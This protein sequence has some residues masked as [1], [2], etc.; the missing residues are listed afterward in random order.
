MFYDICQKKYLD[1]DINIT[2]DGVPLTQVHEIKFLGVVLTD[3]LKWR[4]HADMVVNPF[5]TKTLLRKFVMICDNYWGL[6]GNV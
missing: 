6:D 5:W 4:K 3:D 1:I 2:I